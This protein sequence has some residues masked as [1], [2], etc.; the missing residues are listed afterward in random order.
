MRQWSALVAIFVCL[1][2][3]HPATAFEIDDDDFS[4]EAPSWTEISE[5]KKGATCLDMCL[6][7]GEE[8][9]DCEYYCIQTAKAGPL[10]PKGACSH[11]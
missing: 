4:E 6:A 11:H 10:A 3:G 1:G 5:P 9:F 8:P 2:L 7:D